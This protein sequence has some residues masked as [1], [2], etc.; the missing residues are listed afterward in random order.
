[1]NRLPPRCGQAPHS[2]PETTCSTPFRTHPKPFKQLSAHPLTQR[3]TEIAVTLCPHCRWTLYCLFPSYE[4]GTHTYT[5]THTR[6]RARTLKC[7]NSKTVF[8]PLWLLVYAQKYISA[9]RCGNKMWILH[10]AAER[11]NLNFIVMYLGILI[12]F[13]TLGEYILTPLKRFSSLYFTTVRLRT[14]GHWVFVT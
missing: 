14:K 11:E 12:K 8:I 4:T 6:A 3:V 13:V 1:M 9:Q 7:L 5:H 10:V 2:T